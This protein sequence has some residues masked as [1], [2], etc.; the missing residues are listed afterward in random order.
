M[1]EKKRGFAERVGVRSA[2]EME[3]PDEDGAVAPGVEVG[4]CCCLRGATENLVY[5]DGEVAE[6]PE[7]ETADP[8]AE[9]ESC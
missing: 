9:V 5:A 4:E 3:T 7:T 8:S 2:T 1:S 6:E